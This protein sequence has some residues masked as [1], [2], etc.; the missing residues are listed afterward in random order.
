MV[1]MDDVITY[2]RFS[3]ILEDYLDYRPDYDNIKNYYIQDILKELSNYYKIYIGIDIPVVPNNFLLSS[4]IISSN[5][6]AISEN[7]SFS[8]IS[9]NSFIAM[10]KVLTSSLD[11]TFF[12]PSFKILLFFHKSFV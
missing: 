7:N 8:K 9:V 4:N 2:G 10:V 3:K 6:F 1:D 12:K 11:N 5:C